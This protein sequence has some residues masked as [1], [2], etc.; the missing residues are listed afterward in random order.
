MRARTVLLLW[1]VVVGCARPEGRGLADED[2]S[3]KIPAIKTAAEQKDRDAIPFLIDD[4]NSDDPAVR[5]Y[6]IEALRRITNQ[7]FD[8]DY[9]D[10]APDR[11][12]AVQR[13]RE[14]YESQK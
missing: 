13:W 1:L 2:A 3:F 9:F 12:P 5:F 10:D 4:L 11:A 6:A 14:W 7:T 8:Y